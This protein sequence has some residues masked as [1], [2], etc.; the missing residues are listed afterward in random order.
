MLWVWIRIKHRGSD[1]IRCKNSR[2]MLM[3]HFEAKLSANCQHKAAQATTWS[4]FALVRPEVPSSW[5]CSASSLITNYLILQRLRPLHLL[6]CR[7]PLTPTQVQAWYGFGTSCPNWL[8]LCPLGQFSQSVAA[9]TLQ[10]FSTFPVDF[11]IFL[12][13]LSL[14]ILGFRLSCS[15]RKSTSLPKKPHCSS[16][17]S[18]LLKHV[19]LSFDWSMLD[20]ME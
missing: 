1:H 5:H 12:L 6:P 11:G 9:G 2:C 7:T 15:L 18:P 8:H 4:P 17:L 16:L 10:W 3:P 13:N 19:A 20:L 14:I